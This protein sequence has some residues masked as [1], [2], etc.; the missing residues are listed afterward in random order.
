[1]YGALQ[2]ISLLT[3]LN[4]K[5]VQISLPPACVAFNGAQPCVYQSTETS[6]SSTSSS[7]SPTSSDNKRFLPGPKKPS[8]WWPH[9]PLAPGRRVVKF[10]PI[11]F[12]HKPRIALVR[13]GCTNRPFYTIQIKSNLAESKKLGIEQVGSWDPFPNIHGEQLIALNFER[14]AYWI[15]MGAEPTERV[16]EL[17]GLCGFLPVHPRSYLMAY[18]S[19]IAMM[20]YLERQKQ[21][22]EQEEKEGEGDKETTEIEE[23]SSSTSSVDGE[24]KEPD[25]DSR[26]DSIWSKSKSPSWWYY[27]LP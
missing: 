7:S 26:V 14:I 21:K 25:I 2:R 23:N 10:Y 8:T 9:Q 5:C 6:S 13:E 19:R 27:G 11:R 17:L 15:G 3:N 18:R 22:M 16:A 24:S 4:S 20:K 1:M 12:R